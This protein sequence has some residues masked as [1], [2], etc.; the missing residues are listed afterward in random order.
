MSGQTLRSTFAATDALPLAA[1]LFVAAG[2]RL[3]GLGYGLPAL[4]NA[5]ESYLVNVA[6]SFGRG[7]LNPGIFKYPTLWLYLL[8]GAYGVHFLLW[9]RLGLAHTVREFGHKFIWDHSSFYFIA[10]S[11]S[12][13][14]SLAALLVVDQAARAVGERRVG[15]WAASLLAG[16]VWMVEAAHAAKADSL[17]FLLSA[18]AWLFALRYLRSGRP[19]ELLACSAAAG[20]AASTQYTGAPAALLVPLA[21]AL[22]P[23]AGKPP[24]WG[25]LACSLALL[26]AAFFLA[27]PYALIDRAAFFRDLLDLGRINT[28]GEPYRARALVAAAGFAGSVWVGGPL[29]V[30]GAAA[31]LRKDRPLAALLLSVP[32]MN[33][34]P[35]WLSDKGG[36]MRYLFASMPAMALVA[37]YGV[38]SLAGLL[39]VPMASGLA[40][41]GILALLL[42]PGVFE[43]ALWTRALLLPDTRHD[44][45]RW[46]EANI[47]PGTK[48]LAGDES[49]SPPMRLSKS[50]GEAL[51]ASTK[52]AGHPR[53]RYYELLAESHPGGGF[54]IVRLV[55]DPVEISTGFWHRRWSESGRAVLDVSEGLSAARRNGVQVVVLASETFGFA[56]P[57]IA[58][59][60]EET[61]AQGRLLADFSPV[62]GRV[63][64]PH[65]RVYLVDGV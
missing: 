32:L 11:L 17:M 24:A 12:A 36:N 63:K 4:F 51:L 13:A 38:E 55:R 35:M 61:M 20:L 48:V 65:I 10:R 43:S 45:S 26:P 21:W 25:L 28:A 54:D 60:V 3:H 56:T 14:A 31:L 2:L 44:A 57:G 41:A 49:N 59:F 18:V 34:V 39:R 23:R 50:S 1:V 53:W 52:A 47:P 62:P 27:T 22:R 16:S 9:S 40:R 6:V 19:G 15:L 64:G 8:F 5:D 58:R 29:F 42:A 30:A 33:V 46:I 7:S 37:G